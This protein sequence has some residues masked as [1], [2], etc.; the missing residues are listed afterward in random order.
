MKAGIT[1]YRKKTI[2]YKKANHPIR[3]IGI[4]A[5]FHL[6]FGIG[7]ALLLNQY[8][9]IEKFPAKI[10]GQ[11]LERDMLFKRLATLRTDAAFFSDVDELRWYGP[12]SDFGVLILKME[13]EQFN[14]QAKE[15]W[16]SMNLP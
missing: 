6:D 7:E 13:E 9:S 15:L 4:Y 2:S 11:Q 10:L 12:I 1:C 16:L 5:D 14:E 8:E 3:L